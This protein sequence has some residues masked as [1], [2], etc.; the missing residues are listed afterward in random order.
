MVLPFIKQTILTFFSEIPNL[1][2]YWNGCIGSKVTAV[3]LNGWIFATGRVA[4]GR[5]CPAACAAGLLLSPVG[6]IIWPI[7]MRSANFGGPL[8]K[9]KRRDNSG[10]PKAVLEQNSS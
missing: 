1:E 3:L 5:V 8:K 4:L 10:F 9:K 2:G 6:K 7:G